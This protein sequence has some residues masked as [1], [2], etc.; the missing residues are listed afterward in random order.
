MSLYLNE[1]V[2]YFRLYDFWFKI[3]QF[4]FV[5]TVNL[6]HFDVFF[7]LKRLVRI[8]IYHDILRNHSFIHEII[9]LVNLIIIFRHIPWNMNNLRPISILYRVH[10]PTPALTRHLSWISIR[11]KKF[12]TIKIKTKITFNTQNLLDL[13]YRW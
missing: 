1:I 10:H 5:F 2:Q 6:K 9:F 12:L 7:E 4:K 3:G 8:S 13:F 11:T